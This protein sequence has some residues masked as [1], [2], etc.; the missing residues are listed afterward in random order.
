MS[1][2]RTTTRTTSSRTRTTST[3]SST[4]TS[5]TSIDEAVL[6]SLYKDALGLAP[7]RFVVNQMITLVQGSCLDVLRYALQEA[8]MAPYPSWRY[9]A[10]IMRSCQGINVTVAPGQRLGEAIETARGWKIYQERRRLRLLNQQ[11][12]ETA[13]PY[14]T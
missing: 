6:I 5:S 10:A 14:G 12:D 2:T 8:A 13:M 9:A 7:S 4:S 1:T 3:T 11:D